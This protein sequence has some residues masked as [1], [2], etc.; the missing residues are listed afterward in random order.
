MD[1]FI[2]KK[3][4]NEFSTADKYLRKASLLHERGGACFL[5]I[6]NS[7]KAQRALEKASEIMLR[8]HLEFC[9]REKFKSK[10]GQKKF[11]EIVHLFKI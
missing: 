6:K 7:R 2:K 11:N 3:V 5:V 8:G 10:S 4:L 9:I 1:I